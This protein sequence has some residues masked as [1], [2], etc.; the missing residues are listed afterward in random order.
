MKEYIS[1]KIKDYLKPYTR[2]WTQ[3]E[4]KYLK[5]MFKWLLKWKL[6]TLTKIWRENNKE[7][8]QFVKNLS[9][10]LKRWKTLKY[11]IPYYRRID[12]KLNW[13][14]IIVH[15]E[16]D[17]NKENAKKMEWLTKI[18]DAS[19]K[20]NKIINW[21]KLNWAIAV[22]REWNYKIIPIFLDI[23]NYLWE[24]FKS[25]WESLLDKIKEMLS[26]W[27]WYF[28]IHVFDRWYDSRWFFEKL[29]WLWL[30]FIV[31]ATMKRKIIFRWEEHS[32]KVVV[33]T[34]V[35]ELEKKIKKRQ[36][37]WFEIEEDK[38]I[39]EEIYDKELQ[40]EKYKMTLVVIKRVWY[41]TPMVL[42]TNCKINNE[43][44][45]A[46]DTYKDYLKRW[47]I[48]LYFKFI[49]Q[50]FWLESIQLLEFQV[51]Q[52]FMFLITLLSDFVLVE[53]QKKN[54]REKLWY[55]EEVKEYFKK[56]NIT[57]DTPFWMVDYIWNKIKEEE[58]TNLQLYKK[59]IKKV[60]KN[61]LILR[62][63]ENDTI[64]LGRVISFV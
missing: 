30:K 44:Y 36:I 56:E 41:E 22:S 46:L 61:Q 15:D 1:T 53:F 16:T 6:S 29:F 35:S 23:I 8:W 60:D 42:F 52:K 9:R 43:F 58:K 11:L 14:Y 10:F 2:L 38:V 34:L 48:E 47:N 5:E 49:K 51:L 12:K 33:D 20:E 3:T 57:R 27:I 37:E 62:C 50:K 40:E 18:K 19:S 7:V 31:R 32:I 24:N 59:Q 39:Y 55:F 25:E 54:S 45:T 63:F 17:I 28:N 26:Y 13:N 4:N 21:Y 64:K